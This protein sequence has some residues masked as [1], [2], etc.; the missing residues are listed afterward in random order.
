MVLCNLNKKI[1]T[2]YILGRRK[3]TLDSTICLLFTDIIISNSLY[4]WQY[5]FTDITSWSVELESRDYAGALINGF[6]FV[7]GL[8]SKVFVIG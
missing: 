2:F 7:I 6:I 1:V 8:R 5:M 3:Y 4:L